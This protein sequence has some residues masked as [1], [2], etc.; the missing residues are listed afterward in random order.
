[1][2]NFLRKSLISRFYTGKPALQYESR[3]NR[4]EKWSFEEKSLI[5]LFSDLEESEVAEVADIPVGT[6][7]FGDFLE[8]HPGVR[9]VYCVDLSIDMLVQAMNRQTPKQV[10]MRHDL[11][12]SPPHFNCDTA[13]SFRVLNLFP[14][15]EI[16]KI[17]RNIA[18]VTA[19]NII[20]SVR[21]ADGLSH[22][23]D[24]LAGKV[25]LHGH[26]E[27]YRLISEI[28]FSVK[29][30]CYHPDNKGG[31]YCVLHAVRNT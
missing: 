20:L 8:R 7:R 6:N 10:F 11:L 4:S 2:K 26:V 14:F 17:L 22:H 16:Q 25:Y 9:R 24:I 27:F 13:I 30:E 18:S 28:G 19:T 12:D 21:L 1:M 31:R 23:G 29:A 5:G 15:G 3:R